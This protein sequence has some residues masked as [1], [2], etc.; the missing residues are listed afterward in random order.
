MTY[1]EINAIN[2]WARLGWGYQRIAAQTGISANTVKSYLQRHPGESH[3]VLCQHC[4]TPVEQKP[5]RKEKRY[6][7]DRCR[8]AYWNSHQDEVNKQAF[9]TL[10]CKHCGKE[11][12]SYGNR[13][14]KYCSRLCYANA[15]KK[16]A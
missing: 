3:L 4:G 16:T 7:N 8:M 13:N 5:G 12:T 1:K 14:R 6:C 10:T 2:A 15:R 11:F 9:Y